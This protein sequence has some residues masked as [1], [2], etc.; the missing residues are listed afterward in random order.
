MTFQK[1]NLNLLKLKHIYCIEKE[2]LYW[3]EVQKDSV[4]YIVCKNQEIAK[5]Q[6]ESRSEN[7]NKIRKKLIV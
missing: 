6:A 1:S 4:R 3:Y 5:V 2:N 7:I